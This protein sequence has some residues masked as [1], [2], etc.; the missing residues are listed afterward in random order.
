MKISGFT[1]VR[2]AI[3][4]DYPIV[5]SIKSILPIC[6]EFIVLAGNS[7]DATLELIKSIDSPKIKIHESIW[8]DSLRTG[9]QVLAVETNKAKS[10]VAKDADWL[11]YLQAD[12][13]V[14]EKYLEQILETAKKYQTDFEVEGLLFG[15]M[16]FYGSYAYTADSRKWY[17]REIRLIRND[18]AIQSY[19]DAQGFRKNAGKLNVKLIPAKIYHYGWVKSPY[20]QKEKEK[21]FHKLWHSD[22]WM[23]QNVKQTDSFD[24]SN[25]DS[26]SIFKEEHPAVMIPRIEKANW[27]FTPEI[28][29]KKMNF[30]NKLLFHFEK[31]TGLRLFEYR[32]YKM[33]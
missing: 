5:E 26:L 18:T 32:N 21:S 9:G 20:H 17:R 7:E 33:I 2:N 22:E 16:H 4:Y 24:Y 23:K 15:Y 30:I 10:L 12:E 25:I 1:F 29:E 27:E 6:D 11:F 8:D 28:S 19:G 31:L 14:H 3:K 13:V